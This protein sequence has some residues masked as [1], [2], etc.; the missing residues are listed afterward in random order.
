MLSQFK[1]LL[2]IGFAS[3][4]TLSF[5]GSLQA[6]I[7]VQSGDTIAFLGDSITHQGKAPGGWCGLVI[8]S[9]KSAGIDATQINA[10][11]G[12][13]TSRDMAERFEKDVIAKKP[14][15]MTLLC[16][17]N[18][19]PGHGLPLE[20]SK[21]NITQI[22]ETAQAAGIKVLILTMPV[23][24]GVTKESAYNEFI[25][26]FAR[27]KGIPLADVFAA[28]K[29]VLEADIAKNGRPA[30]GSPP[31][32]TIADGTHMNG[33]GNQ[34]I[35]ESVLSA[36]GFSPEQIAKAEKN[37]PKSEPA[38]DAGPVAEPKK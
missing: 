13:N 12:G 30:K 10:G 6:E 22:I 20:E 9:L 17:T 29:K 21:K 5:V 2:C 31:L 8:A 37:W 27:E 7:L 23:R 1:R 35:A 18:D 15:W 34:V 4:L 26:A 14:A 36:L 11:V 16:G 3:V 38:K 32:L 24:G 28:G 33:L 25:R 19:N